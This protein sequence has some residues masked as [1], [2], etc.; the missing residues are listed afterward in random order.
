[1]SFMSSEL[2]HK[3]GSLKPSHRKG[4][5]ATMLRHASDI[6]LVSIGHLCRRFSTLHPF[7]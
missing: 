1:M 4:P 2:E 5:S 3:I 6:H 7:Q